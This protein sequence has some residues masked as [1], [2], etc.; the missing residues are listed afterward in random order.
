MT[1]DH[2]G[3]ELQVGDFPFCPHGP[4]GMAAHADEIPGGM[5]VENGF[6]HPVK[7]YSHSEHR[8]L[9]AERGLEIRAKWAGEHDKVMSN[10]AAGIDAQ[11]LAN[12]VALVS[13]G[14]TVLAEKPSRWP[15]ATEPITVTDGSTFKSKDLA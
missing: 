14:V 12:A 11:T 6:E 4:T 15:K 7:V 13:R 2:C 1:C 3:R 5:W 9:L 8:R 10:W